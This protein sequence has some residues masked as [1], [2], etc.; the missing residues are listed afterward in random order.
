[1]LRPAVVT[2]LDVM[3]R[4]G[5]EALRIEELAVPASVAGRPPAALDLHR[6]RRMLLLL[7]PAKQPHPRRTPFL[8]LGCLH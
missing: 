7:R 3:L 2:F 1:M 4:S 8:L 5:D 6:F